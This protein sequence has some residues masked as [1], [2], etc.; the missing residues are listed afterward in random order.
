MNTYEVQ[1]MESEIRN[2][3][4]PRLA[5]LKA[6][7]SLTRSSSFQRRSGTAPPVFPFEH[8]RCARRRAHVAIDVAKPLRRGVLL[9]TR[10]DGNPE[11]FDIQYEKLPFYCL[12]C[13]VMGHSE[14]ECAQ[15][16]VRND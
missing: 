13:G 10:R 16:L 3:R 8:H 5:T 11:W 15:P 1:Q 12:S 9:K 2:Y 4:S 6:I 14:L 7:P